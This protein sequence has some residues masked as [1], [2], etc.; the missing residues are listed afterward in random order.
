[1]HD[2]VTERGNIPEGEVLLPRFQQER[3]E[4]CICSFSRPPENLISRALLPKRTK[5][6]FSLAIAIFVSRSRLARGPSAVLPYT[7]P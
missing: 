1:M 5:T 4:L 7:N 3:R 2:S 6:I